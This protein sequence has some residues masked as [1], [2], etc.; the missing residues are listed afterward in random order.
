MALQSTQFQPGFPEEREL[1]CGPDIEICLYELAPQIT[2]SLT[3]EYG[4]VSKLSAYDG[5]TNMVTENMPV[6]PD[7]TLTN[8]ERGEKVVVKT[9]AIRGGA[10]SLFP[11]FSWGL[12]KQAFKILDTQVT[13]FQ[14]LPLSYKF[15]I[16]S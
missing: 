5:V 6:F 14:I 4:R 12:D 3:G 1:M 2:R 8:W 15:Y 7:N 11:A 13:I 16:F 10:K 9:K